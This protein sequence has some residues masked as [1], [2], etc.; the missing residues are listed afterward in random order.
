[1]NIVVITGSYYPN[2]SA[3]GVCAKNIVDELIHRGHQVWVICNVTSLKDANL[4]FEGAGV[5]Y[6][7]TKEIVL[8]LKSKGAYRQIVRLYYFLKTLFLPKS[9]K[10]DTISA[11]EKC[12]DGVVADELGGNCPDLILGMVFPIESILASIE[13]KKRSRGQSKLIPVIF[14]NFVEN[15][16]LH[17]LA[18]NRKLKR[19]RHLKLMIDTFDECDCILVMHNQKKY[20]Y[21]NGLL[22]PNKTIFVEHPLLVPPSP[23]VLDHEEYS[24]SINLLYSGSFLRN[25]V[26]SEHLCELVKALVDADSSIKAEFC[27]MGNDI[28]NVVRLSKEYPNSVKNYGKVPMSIAVEKMN[29]ADVFLCV[30]EK[31]GRQM[32][33]KIFTYMS[34]GKPIVLVYYCDT[35]INKNVL[36]RYPLLFAIRADSIKNCI[37][38]LLSFLKEKGK[39]KLSFSEVS[40][41]YKD[42]LPATLCDYLLA[43]CSPLKHN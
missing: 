34:F 20:Y 25:Y 29:S 8:R 16:S 32:S 9:I 40:N 39:K 27:V 43:S 6:Y 5:R 22:R 36:E 11:M 4:E 41:L 12:L 15:P 18:I 7:Q 2:Y 35:D 33:S 38:E 1:M 42:A 24:D 17:R 21:D 31:K 3:V 19:R 30:A 13:W 26:V 28:D 14:D 23:I 37:P 10:R